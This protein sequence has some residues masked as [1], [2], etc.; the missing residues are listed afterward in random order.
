MSKNKL[1]NDKE[2]I[3]DLISQFNIVK[4]EIE[5]ELNQI[6]SINYKVYK[7]EREKN[8]KIN[9]SILKIIALKRKIQQGLYQFT[10][11]LD[12]ITKAD[13]LPETEDVYS[14][15]EQL[16]SKLV[17]LQN[18]LEVE[19]S[20][21][22][23]N[24]KKYNDCSHLIKQQQAETQRSLKNINMQILGGF[25]GVLGLTT[26]AVAFVV[27]NASTFG[28]PGLVIAGIG[29]TT[30][31]LGFGL[32]KLGSYKNGQKNSDEN[33]LGYLQII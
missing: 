10:V 14:D 30:A 18:S 24:I 11:N 20:H 26:V 15:Y 25:I 13:E 19:A 5:D 8:D 17:E 7:E 33:Q 3:E 2:K 31:L 32:F 23:R 28:V 29:V 16:S 27:F 1:L 12:E 4:Q 21:K 9:S 22:A 6:S